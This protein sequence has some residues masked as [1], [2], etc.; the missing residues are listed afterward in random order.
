MADHVR[1]A[2]AIVVVQPAGSSTFTAAAHVK[3]CC[4]AGFGYADQPELSRYA[5]Q[6]SETGTDQFGSL[7]QV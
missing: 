4:Q 7:P 5:L 1:P 3:V 2:P 6:L